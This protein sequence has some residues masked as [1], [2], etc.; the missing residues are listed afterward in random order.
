VSFTQNE[1]LNMNSGGR[2]F[3]YTAGPPGYTR[4]STFQTTPKLFDPPCKTSSA[5]TNPP[6]GD[7]PIAT[8]L[9]GRSVSATRLETFPRKFKVT[10]PM[11][12]APAALALSGGVKLHNP[13]TPGVGDYELAEPSAQASCQS[14]FG[15]AKNKRGPYRYQ[16]GTTNQF[17]SMTPMWWQDP[18][19][20]TEGTIGAPLG[21][22]GFKG[23]Q[24]NQFSLP[25]AARTIRR[26]KVV[27]SLSVPLRTPKGMVAVTGMSS[28]TPS[29]RQLMQTWASSHSKLKDI[30]RSKDQQVAMI[31][32]ERSG[33][34]NDVQPRYQIRPNDFGYA[35]APFRYLPAE[36]N[37]M[38]EDPVTMVRSLDSFACAVR[39]DYDS[40]T[41]A[42][43][44]EEADDAYVFI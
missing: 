24:S 1:A 13:P 25:P 2:C 29:R 41:Q 7:Y 35:T 21:V 11:E 38:E 15:R 30:E 39:D 22:P 16:T 17:R 31:W 37:D 18:H 28:P 4:T 34:I 20:G 40:Q 36:D 19:D 44:A 32:A 12:G 42:V 27:R 23:R 8:N 26:P 5:V 9:L 6:V 43:Q 14:T 10:M 33:I 3:T